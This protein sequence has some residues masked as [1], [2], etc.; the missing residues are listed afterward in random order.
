MREHF[1]HI[2][3]YHGVDIQ[4]E[5]IEWADQNLAGPHFRFSYV[6]V[7]NERYNPEGLPDR[8]LAAAPGSV[9]VFYAYSVFSHMNDEGGRPP[10][11]LQAHRRGPGARRP[12]VRDLLRG[13]G[14]GPM[15]GEP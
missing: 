6:N 15:G 11:Y 12:G 2:R 14:R 7:S 9:D 10:A 1:G 3:D 13:G 5:L 8:T 4:A